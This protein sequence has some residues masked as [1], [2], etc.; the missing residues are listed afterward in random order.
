VTRRPFA[1]GVAFGLVLGF[2]AAVLVTA[3]GVE[4]YP[5]LPAPHEAWKQ[6]A[7]ETFV[8]DQ[9]YFYGHAPDEHYAP[10][11]SRWLDEA[12]YRF[13]QLPES[14]EGK[15]MVRVASARLQAAVGNPR[16]GD[17]WPFPCI[18]S[19][20]GSYTQPPGYHLLAYQFAPDTLRGWLDGAGLGFWKPH[21]YDGLPA[22][23]QDQAAAYG[24]ATEG[25]EPWPPSWDGCP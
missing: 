6:A 10:A 22:Y 7:I 23:V 8:E 24:F 21:I 4:Q 19:R 9:I 11:L 2:V 13:D 12:I 15:Q 18:R 20:E 1:L 5:P 3:P 25:F 14:H 16:L 17:R